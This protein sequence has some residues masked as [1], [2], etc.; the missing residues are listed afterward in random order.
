MPRSAGYQGHFHES[1][2]ISLIRFNADLDKVTAMTVGRLALDC[3]SCA[4]LRG[5]MGAR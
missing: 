4:R 2:T 3:I 5:R 1:E